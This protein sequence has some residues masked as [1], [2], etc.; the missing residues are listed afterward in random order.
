[1]IYIEDVKPS[2]NMQADSI[3]PNWV[4]NIFL[5][6]LYFVSHL[7]NNTGKTFKYFLQC[8]IF[9]IEDITRLALAAS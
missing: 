1:M 6:F 3:R 8:F 5:H 7:E 4:S 2:L 9:Y